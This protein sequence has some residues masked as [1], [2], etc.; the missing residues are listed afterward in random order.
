MRLVR[1]WL[2]L[3]TAA[4][5]FTAAV[6]DEQESAPSIERSAT[7]PL[8]KGPS[9]TYRIKDF[10]PMAIGNKWVY[11]SYP[12][13]GTGIPQK[14]GTSLEVIAEGIDGDGRKYWAVGVQILDASGDPTFGFTIQYQ[15]KGR[16]RRSALGPG[17][18][19]REVPRR[20]T[21][22]TDGTSQTYCMLRDKDD[23][24]LTVFTGQGTLQDIATP[25]WIES[26]NQEFGFEVT[27]LYG[28]E[29]LVGT[30]KSNGSDFLPPGEPEYVLREGVGPVVIR[31]DL[32]QYARI[33][34][35]EYTFFA[36]Q[37]VSTSGVR[38]ELASYP[39]QTNAD[40]ATRTLRSYGMWKIRNPDSFAQCSASVGPW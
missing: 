12:D 5:C 25:E 19:T 35:V 26:R 2:Y 33:N 10:W 18:A 28:E 8:G 7:R 17:T 13:P 40:G 34:G 29:S 39:V 30:C 36:Y 22:F 23:C 37:Q 3:V 24:F 6:A 14:Q 20:I 38:R 11:V 32:L 27:Q 16:F 15:N 4:I 31:K 9:Q 1:I 21:V